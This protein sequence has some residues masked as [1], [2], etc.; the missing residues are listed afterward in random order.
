MLKATQLALPVNLAEHY[1]GF[2]VSNRD[3]LVCTSDGST[4]RLWYKHLASSDR[5][6]IPAYG[7]EIMSCVMYRSVCGNVSCCSMASYTGGLG[8]PRVTHVR[9][10]RHRLRQPIIRGTSLAT[11]VLLGYPSGLCFSRSRLWNRSVFMVFVQVGIPIS[12][13]RA[14]SNSS[15]RE[16]SLL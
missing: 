5:V 8:Y 4:R 1:I 12:G 15:G 3:G 2:S 13:A 14:S 7:P 11:P 10:A 9:S 6:T 16:R